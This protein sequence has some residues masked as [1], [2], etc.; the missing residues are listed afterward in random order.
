MN[1]LKPLKEEAM[2]FSYKDYDTFPLCYFS[3]VEGR[4]KDISVFCWTSLICDWH[5]EPIKRFHPKI[6]FPFNKMAIKAI[7]QMRDY[8][9]RGVR[10]NRFTKIVSENL[11]KFPIYISSGAKEEGEIGKNHLLLPEGLFF[12]LFE[13]GTDRDKLMIELE[14]N[15]QFFLRGLNDKTVSKDRV[16]SGIRGNYSLIF[17]ER[18]NFWQGVDVDRAITNYKNALAL[19]PF[20]PPSQLNLGFAYIDK[21]DYDHAMEVF[22]KMAEENPNYNPSLLHYGFGLV[23]QN[24]EMIDKAI[25]EYELAL[26]INPNNIY[27]KHSLQTIKQQNSLVLTTSNDIFNYYIK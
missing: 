16:A 27:A 15:P 21:K 2:I 1:I 18:G 22:G 4:R 11:I 9:L 17:N 5:I 26:K 20:Y 3:Y 10:R 8:D 14:K 25:E 19:T 24:R 7:T 6:L 13:K 12:R 23:Y